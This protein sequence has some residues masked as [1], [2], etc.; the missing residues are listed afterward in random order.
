MS[1]DIS[2][3]FP[4]ITLYFATAILSLLFLSSVPL[5][6]VHNL[7]CVYVSCNPL[8]RHSIS[9]VVYSPIWDDSNVHGTYYR[10]RKAVVGIVKN[11]KSNE[12]LVTMKDQWTWLKKPI[13]W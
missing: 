3:T 5:V 8:P 4:Y 13:V 11:A 7:F 10:R 6:Y 9:I 12:R 2:S 1:D